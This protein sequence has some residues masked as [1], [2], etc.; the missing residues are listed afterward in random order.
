[1]KLCALQIPFAFDKSGAAESVDQ[2]ISLLNSCDSSCDI[3]LTPEYS[4]APA[5]LPEGECIPF[6]SANSPRLLAAAREAAIRCNAIVAVNYVADAGDGNFR[7][8]TEIFDRSG[9]SRGRFCKQHLTAAEKKINKLDDS[10]TKSFTAPEIIEI[11]GIRFGFM[12]CYDTYFCE[13][14]A[15]LASRHPDVVL[16]SSFQRA[17]RRDII[18][19]QNVHLAFLCNAFVLRASVS[20]G[21]DSELGGNSLAVSS[22]GRILGE[23]GSACGRFDFEAGDIK[24]KYMRSNSFGGSE[25]PNDRFIEQAR[26]PWAYRPCGSMTVLPDSL[27]PYPRVCAHRGF[28]SAM[29]E[30]S[31]AALGAAIALGAQEIEIDVRFTSDKVP[32]VAHDSNLERISN[33]TGFIEEKTFAELRT[34]DFSEGRPHF[35]GLQIA[36]FEEVLS[37]FARHAILNLHLKTDEQEGEVYPDWQMEMVLELLYKYDMAAHTYFMGCDAVMECA[38]RHAPEIARC[39]GAFPNPWQQVERA[40]KYKCSKIQLFGPYYNQEMIDKAKANGII[41]NLFFCDTPEDVAGHLAAGVDTIL[42]N[43]YW[44]VAQKVKEALCTA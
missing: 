25:I 19:M 39:M 2:L 32:V 43:D 1:M 14:A 40:L 8:T 3:I 22:D 36:T 37:R 9:K 27:M 35:E 30:N 33:G 38:L 42:T 4:N 44:S 7:N 16:V 12:I 29:P 34:L 23:A 31:L 15:H 26:A 24:T 11:D 13:Y 17:E 41:C 21:K 18:R 6:A 10:Y 5:A 20:M 28:N